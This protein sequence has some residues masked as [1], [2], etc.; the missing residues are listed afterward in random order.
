VLLD[1]GV[2]IARAQFGLLVGGIAASMDGAEIYVGTSDGTVT[3][4]DSALSPQRELQVDGRVVGLE[5]SAS[6]ALL[7]AH[8]IGAF[9]SNYFI[10][11]FA[12]GATTPL[13]T[14]ATFTISALDAQGEQAIYGT[15]NSRLG[16]VDTTRSDAPAWTTLLVKPITSILA[17]PQRDQILAGS[18]SGDLSLLSADGALLGTL[19]ISQYPI[20]ALV[21]DAGS[22]SF[23]VGDAHGNVFMLND[24]GVTIFSRRLAQSDIAALIPDGDGRLVVVPREGQWQLMKP[25]LAYDLQRASTLRTP[26]LI[27][28]ALGGVLLLIALFVVVRRLRTTAVA[29]WRARTAYLFLLPT[30]V[31]LGLFFY[32]PTALSA[33]Y[34]VT[35]F[36]LRGATEFV[37]LD[38]Y[39]Q[40]LTNDFYFRVGIWN[41]IILIVT[42]ILK[43]IT[44]P[45]LVAEL[46]FWLRNS[47][48]QYIFRTLFVLPTVVPALVFILLWQQVY[49]P[50]IG[51]L[52]QLLS[53]VGLEEWRTAWLGN[54]RTALW[55]IVGIGFPWID[56]FAFLILLGGLLNINSEYFDAAKIDGANRWQTFL[57]I[58]LPLLAPQLR[59]LTFFAVTGVI[60]GF[61]GILLLTRGGPGT[62]TYVPALQMYL[63]IASGDYGYA[64]AIGFI[65]FLVTM[66]ATLVVLRLG[67]RNETELA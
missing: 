21:Y 45:L 9:T 59:L 35:T 17:V 36:S 42:G 19:Q 18:E 46:I 60:T 8:G 43:T 1:Q 6:G 48:H 63:R 5:I 31:L 7:V 22:S 4:L 55:A 65:L 34:S 49:D 14:Q 57:R 62:A 30:F 53:A 61:A 25:A 66:V 32:Y 58:D 28:N 67:R 24:Q 56:A 16:A 26:W 39:V 33:Y 51:L 13:T 44:V 3:V 10:S 2:P 50:N 20:R 11:S 15:A 40:I 47:V 64:S 54:E 27:W 38:N 52:N 29:A 12:P 23:L 41:M 37:G